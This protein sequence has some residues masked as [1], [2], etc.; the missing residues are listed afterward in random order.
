MN[1]IQYGITASAVVL[2]LIAVP[3][4][5]GLLDKINKDTI[6]AA[7]DVAKSV[8]L[9]ESQMIDMSKKSAKEMDS[10][11]PISE[12][13][14]GADK[15]YSERLNRLFAPHQ[16]EDG[17]NLNYK[18]YVVKDF[19]AFA[20]P[21]GSIRVFA[22]LMDKLTD[23]EILAIIGHEIGHV[24]LKHSLRSY[25]NALL[26][27][28]VRKGVASAGGSAGGLASGQFGAVGQKFVDS[29]F[30]Q[31]HELEADL[32]GINFLK[33]HGYD[34]KAMVSAFRKMKEISGNG[35][36]LLASHPATSKRIKKMEAQLD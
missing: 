25:K 5:A 4:Q 23:E 8:T 27:S 36:G 15:K 7:T 17:L 31:S 20:T 13:Q 14:T 21:D 1:K 34:P 16:N 9:T 24:K 29:Q 33:K 35:G 22:G 26:A 19:N 10:N 3:L 30:S 12:E 11:N 28:G 18:A 6:G 2:T 32:Y